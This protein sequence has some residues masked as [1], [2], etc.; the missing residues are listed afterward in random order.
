VLY[1]CLACGRSTWRDDR[2]ELPRGDER[3]SHEWEP[4]IEDQAV[5]LPLLL[6][7]VRAVAEYRRCWE[8]HF[9]ST[10]IDDLNAARRD[11]IRKAEAALAAVEGRAESGGTPPAQG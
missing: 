6:A 4:E 7:A 9:K 8:D 5:T 2:S 11:M 10:T 1:R 3:C